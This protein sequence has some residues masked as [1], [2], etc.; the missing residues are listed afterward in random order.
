MRWSDRVGQRLK[1][2]ELHVLMAVAQ[3]GSMAKAARDLAVS[4]PV[5]SK[6]IADLEG[7]L[8]V[9]LLDR[10]RE[11]IE[12]TIYGQALL[13]RGVTI[14]DELRQSVE[15]LAFLADP[16]VGEL[17]I[18]ATEAAMAGLLPVIVA[19]LR[20]RHPRLTFH[21]TQAVSG[22]SLQHELRARKVDL[23][24]GSMAPPIEDGDLSVEVLFD[25]PMIVVAGTE[26]RWARRRSIELAQLIDEPWSLPRLDSAPGRRVVETF[27]ACGL[28][29]PRAC[30]TCNSVTMHNALVANSDYLAMPAPHVLVLNPKHI[31]VKVLPVKLPSIPGPTG[32]TTLSNREMTPVAR[33]FIEAARDVSGALTKRLAAL[34][35]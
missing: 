3:H 28:A 6:T 15:E 16:T 9:K 35:R 2:R 20:R 17:R 30:V 11:G 23:I 4:Q 26:N 18:G 7:T 29:M 31:P 33:V 10:T 21:L 24:I 27:R 22:A 13:R 8:G 5:V 34:V 32:I 14:F 1:L 19:R 25:E 12:P